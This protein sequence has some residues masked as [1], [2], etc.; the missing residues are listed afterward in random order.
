MNKI[1]VTSAV[2]TSIGLVFCVSSGQAALIAYDGAPTG[3]GGY[4][5]GSGSLT[6]NPSA[7]VGF[8]GSWQGVATYS[9]QA[10]SL[11]YFNLQTTGGSF[12]STST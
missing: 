7:T 11:S 4:A 12:V 6:G 9:V 8:T 2:L 5:V 3:S 10:T 1:V